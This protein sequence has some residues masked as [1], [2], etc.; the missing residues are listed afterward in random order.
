MATKC[1]QFKPG[2][3]LICTQ[4]KG[5]TEPVRF[6]AY[7]NANAAANPQGSASPKQPSTPLAIVVRPNGKEITVRVDQLSR[8]PIAAKSESMIHR[9]ETPRSREQQNSSRGFPSVRP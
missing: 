2:D 3:Q 1:E 8:Q 9:R 7:S 6:K 5:T 4:G